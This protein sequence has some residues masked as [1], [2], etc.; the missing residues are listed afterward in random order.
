MT[1]DAVLI[2]AGLRGRLV[3]GRWARKNPERL[4]IVAVAEPDA[5]RRAAV[6]REHGL[7]AAQV[8]D[9]WRALL[10]APQLAPTRDRR[11]RRHAARRARA[12]RARSAAT[13]CCSRSRS[14]R[15]AADCVRVVAAA[16]RAAASCRSATCCA[17]RRSTRACTRSSPSG[18][19]GRVS[20]IDMQEHVAYWHMAHSYVRG[21]VPQP[22]ARRADRARQ[23]LPR[24]RPADLVRRGAAGARVARSARSSHFR[25]ASAPPGAPE[26]CTARLPRAGELPVRRRALLP[27]ARRARR[28]PL[29]VERRRRRSR[30]RGAPACARARSVR[31]LRLPLRQRRPRPP[32]AWRSSSRTALPRRSPCTASRATRSAPSASPGSAGELRGVLHEGWIEVTRHGAA[33]V[34]THR[35][36]GLAARSLRRRRRPARPLHRR[37][38]ARRARGRARVG[39]G[40]AREPPARLR[41][42]GV[43]LDGAGGGARAGAPC[44]TSRLGIARRRRPRRLSVSSTSRRARRRPRRCRAR[45]ARRRVGLP[46][47]DPAPRV[48]WSD[49]SCSSL[50]ECRGWSLRSLAAN[51]G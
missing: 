7:A 40:L 18:R 43:P 48:Q 32:G 39:P 20:S 46:G 22:R 34:E 11:D 4:R 27:R 31:R 10:A 44:D 19:L 49:A 41:R 47:A 21:Q 26:R 50:Q 38:R 8:F 37:R 12:R 2:G 13:T 33:G 51:P 6:A 28:A 25:G 36:R 9:D 30:A 45:S 35:G 1:I 24:P 16:E 23:E 15:R 3:Y 29:A 17:T 42:G 5:G 14:H